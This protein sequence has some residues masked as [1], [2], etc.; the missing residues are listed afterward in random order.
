[1]DDFLKNPVKLFVC[2]PREDNVIIHSYCVAGGMSRTCTRAIEEYMAHHTRASADVLKK[3]FGKH[4]EE[5]LHTSAELPHIRENKGNSREYRGSGDM[6]ELAA[7]EKLLSKEVARGQILDTMELNA[8]IARGYTVNTDI[9]IF[10]EDN[11][12][13]L[14]EKA[15]IITGIPTYRM[16]VFYYNPGIN[17]TYE[18]RDE[19]PRDINIISAFREPSNRLYGI[20]IDKRLHI[21]RDTAYVESR[22][23]FITIGTSHAHNNEFYIVDLANLIGSARNQLSAKM[24]DMQ[25]ME[26]MYYGFILKFFPALTFD[27]F[28]DFLRDERELFAKYPDLARNTPNLIKQYTNEQKIASYAHDMRVQT[29]ALV[30]SQEITLAI[31]QVIGYISSQ[32]KINIRNAFDL[33]PAS[34]NTPE[35]RAYIKHNGN[36]YLLRKRHKSAGDIVFPNHA[37]FKQG[38][39]FCISTEAQPMFLA[40]SSEGRSM[41]KANWVDERGIVF[42]ESS[43]L[44]A[45]YANPVIDAVNILGAPA[46]GY[47]ILN[48][49]TANNIIYKGLTTCVFWKRILS[50]KNFAEFRAYL[51][52]YHEARIMTEKVS[53]MKDVNEYKF[54]KGI[55]EYDPEILSRILVAAKLGNI[56]NTY[57]YISNPSIRAKW[58]QFYDGRKI[59]ITHRISD[60]RFEITNIYE[61]EFATFMLY[62]KAMIYQFMREVSLGAAVATKKLGKLKEIDPELFNLKKHNSKKVYSRL[63]QKRWQPTV[64][65]QPE[66]DA[67]SNR[68]KKHITRF[69]NFTTKKPAYYACNNDKFPYLSFISGH[70]RGY[71]LPC[72]S[73]KNPA[74]GFKRA[75]VMKT[76]LETHMMPDIKPEFVA[77]HVVAYGKDIQPARLG[78]LPNN[79]MQDIFHSDLPFYLLGVPQ[80]IPGLNNMGILH[81]LAAL[82]DMSAEDFVLSLKK[83]ICPREN[84]SIFASLAGGLAAAY[85][86]DARTMMDDLINLVISDRH[87]V[88]YFEFYPDVLSEMLYVFSN[89]TPIFFIDAVGDGE[90]VEL[91]IPEFAKNE[92]LLRETRGYVLIMK[93]KNN[94]YPIIRANTR[95]YFTDG[96]INDRVFASGDI[97]NTI[98]N[99][100]RDYIA[101]NTINNRADFSLIK[102]FAAAKTGYTIDTA[103]IN[104]HG[105][106]YMLALTR[107]EEHVLFPIEPSQ[108][109]DGINLEFSYPREL[110]SARHLRTFVNTYNTYIAKHHGDT[111]LQIDLNTRVIYDGKYIGYIHENMY[112]FAQFDDE[113]LNEKHASYTLDYDIIAVNCAILSNLPPSE[114]DTANHDEYIYKNHMYKLL[115]I[116]FASYL[117]TE[118][119]MEVRAKLERANLS[120]AREIL[121]AYPAEDLKKY[122]EIRARGENPLDAR[123]MFDKLALSRLATD[124][125]GCVIDVCAKIVELRAPDYSAGFKFPNIYTSCHSPA[126][127]C[128]DGKLLLDCDE[129]RFREFQEILIAEMKDP[130]KSRLILSKIWAGNV[131]R[132]FNFVQYADETISVYVI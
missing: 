86:N 119:N 84:A 39:I 44:I 22:E 36:D 93:R 24:G 15:Q 79:Y 62:L 2:D 34:V 64:Y 101:I 59:S 7:I 11:L 16:H 113:P 125:A 131:S 72:C 85:Y 126:P 89:I 23:V 18:L 40:I 37:A 98:K 45:K 69:W 35:I 106:A 130:I 53:K 47:G 77:K 124:P 31:T 33:S 74:E 63:C 105:F 88:K 92:F 118:K 94:F 21:A 109:T 112:Y 76:C 55:H 10:G 46:T 6:D 57:L 30:R 54:H 41:I 32:V 100:A 102:E 61:D 70:P 67:L 42:A 3:H 127:Y 110:C 17:A 9:R 60:L 90:N 91:Y 73:K 99:I 56:N 116:E 26:I 4:F 12:V 58:L 29:D 27:C 13:E 121:A 122:T 123:Y 68:A 50:Q 96:S 20:P 108:Y 104:A 5:I 120:A 78:N 19:Y 111:Y 66:F 87:F 82:M 51:V 52:K 43:R 80:A 115:V 97:I 48:K 114:D 14:K 128:A 95:A 132:M 81:S 28:I 8:Q 1:M 75:D 129:A 103:Y 83:H 25:T 38:I 65:S 107:K 49:F 117:E 71:C